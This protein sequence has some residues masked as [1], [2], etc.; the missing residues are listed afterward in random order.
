[1]N[2]RIRNSFSNAKQKT[3]GGIIG[4]AVAHPAPSAIPVVVFAAKCTLCKSSYSAWITGYG[5]KITML[6]LCSVFTQIQAHGE[7]V[8]SLAKL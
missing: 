1:M 6:L 7:H 3:P 8:R 5:A 4:G 2:T